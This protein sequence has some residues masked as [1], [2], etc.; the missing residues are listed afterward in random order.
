MW[1][2]PLRQEPNAA[3]R[4]LAKTEAGAVGPE[5]YAVGISTL[6]EAQ[7][8]PL[9]D[10]A[11]L[12]TGLSF[13]EAHWVA[14]VIAS[15]AD[16]VREAEDLLFDL[17]V[18]VDLTWRDIDLSSEVIEP[19]G[20]RSQ[21]LMPW[22]PTGPGVPVGAQYGIATYTLDCGHQSVEIL[23]QDPD[24]AP[25]WVEEAGVEELVARD[26]R[27][28]ARLIINESTLDAAH[29]IVGQYQQNMVVHPEDDVD[30]D[31]D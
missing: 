16:R 24:V 7:L 20:V 5:E 11:D 15:A 12:F 8:A 3:V 9:L 23:R 27:S 2:R 25:F 1:R 10:E 30:E 19:G 17:R 26:A 13:A 29:G 4:V 6:P 28:L 31:E 22:R 14:A 18:P 21:P